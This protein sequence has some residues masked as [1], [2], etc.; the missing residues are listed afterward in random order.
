MCKIMEISYYERTLDVRGKEAERLAGYGCD[1]AKV[2]LVEGEDVT[3]VV[4]LGEDDVGG[5][6]KPEVEVGVAIEDTAGDG[7]VSVRERRETVRG[8]LDLFKKR[9]LGAAAD[10]GGEQVIE[11]GED[12]RREHERWLGVFERPARRD[13]VALGGVDGGQEAARVE[14]YHRS[15][16]PARSSSSTRSARAGAPDAVPPRG[17]AQRPG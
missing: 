16:K 5:V 11:L 13:V 3:G 14:Q 8:S 12:E 17:R 6:G 7:D 9:G 1:G 2:A 15:P 4:A 10:P